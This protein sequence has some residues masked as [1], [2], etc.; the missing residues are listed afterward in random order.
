MHFIMV[1]FCIRGA[2]KYG[3]ENC[4]EIGLTTCFSWINIRIMLSE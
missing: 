3:T 2:P 1:D 4:V